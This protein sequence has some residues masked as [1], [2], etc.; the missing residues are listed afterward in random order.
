MLMNPVFQ[1]AW[2]WTA[3]QFHKMLYMPLLKGLPHQC[4]HRQEESSVVYQNCKWKFSKNSAQVVAVMNLPS[5]QADGY[6]I[7]IHDI[8]PDGSLDELKKHA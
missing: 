4:G 6:V 5:N 2:L 7:T 3:K 1:Y 8:P